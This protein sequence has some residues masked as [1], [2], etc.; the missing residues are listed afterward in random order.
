M[1]DEALAK[2]KCS[3]SWI[4]DNFLPVSDPELHMIEDLLNALV[5]EEDNSRN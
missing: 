1:G 4:K 5:V 2:L 3:K